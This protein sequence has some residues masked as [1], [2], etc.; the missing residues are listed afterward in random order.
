M[1]HRGPKEGPK[2]GL[3]GTPYKVGEKRADA[4]VGP[5]F[6]HQEDPKGWD[7]ASIKM[8]THPLHPMPRVT[9]SDLLLPSA[10][11]KLRLTA[12]CLA[13]G[14]AFAVL[15]YFPLLLVSYATTADLSRLIVTTLVIAGCGSAIMVFFAALRSERE[16]QRELHELL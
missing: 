10:T 5:L 7:R 8:K 15:C 9:Q 13:F 12:D 4:P 14:A 1:P 3:Y 6:G 2:L 16:F 11:D